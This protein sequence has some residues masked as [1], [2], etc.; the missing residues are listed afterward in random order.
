MESSSND[1]F[2]N[3]DS[4]NVSSEFSILAITSLRCTRD[5]PNLRRGRDIKT[6]A[7]V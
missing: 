3:T 4:A 2:Y 7:N 6:V 5:V 1:T